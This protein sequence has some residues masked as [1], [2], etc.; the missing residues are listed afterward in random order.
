LPLRVGLSPACATTSRGQARHHVESSPT[1]KLREGDQVMFCLC[2]CP[3][4]NAV[5]EDQAAVCALHKGFTRGLLDVLAPQA[6]LAGFVPHDPD[7]AG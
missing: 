2:N 4:A 3:Y 5:H 1:V 7:K 6:K